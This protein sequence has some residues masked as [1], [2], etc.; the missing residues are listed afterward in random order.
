MLLAIDT[1]GVTG[2][3][4]LGQWD[5]ARMTVLAEA[6]LAAK[7]FSAQLI[8]RLRELLR[9]R[10]A[11][12]QDL[13]TIVVVNGPGSFTGVRVGVGAAKGLAEALAVPV[14]AL[15]R[16]ALL[17][18]KGGTEA[19][20]IDAGRGEFYFLHRAEGGSAEFLLSADA[21][22]EYAGEP[23]AVFEASLAQHWAGTRLVAPPSATDALL[24]AIPR[25]RAKEFDDIVTLDGNYVR[26]SDAELFAKPVTGRR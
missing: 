3:I 22:G 17:A 12:V 19:A 1:C 14:I 25:L 16:L 2:T 11:T 20:A 10:S 4:A 24:G 18:R 8:P 7:T 21:A 15:S 26:R 23:I 6:E 5:G 13:R 9:E